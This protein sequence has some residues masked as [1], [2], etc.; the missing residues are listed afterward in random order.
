MIY[1]AAL[2]HQCNQTMAGDT[3]E[4]RC[5]LENWI[6][7]DFFLWILEEI[8]INTLQKIR[9]WNAI[10]THLL[11]EGDVVIADSIQSY[12]FKLSLISNTSPRFQN[13]YLESK[14]PR[15]LQHSLNKRTG[16]ISHN[17]NFSIYFVRTRVCKFVTWVEIAKT[18][19]NGNIS[20]SFNSFSYYTVDF[21]HW[22]SAR[23]CALKL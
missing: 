20:H 13:L 5:H 22:W 9:D 8:K 19:P 10:S 4:H 7:L 18:P 14:L 23:S 11:L 15:W 3:S 12:I 6:L 21:W 2:V 17:S 1:H 16:G